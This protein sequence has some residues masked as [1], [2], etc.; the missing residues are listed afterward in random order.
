MNDAEEILGPEHE[1][2]LALVECGES[3]GLLRREI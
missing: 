1:H 3:N 2:T